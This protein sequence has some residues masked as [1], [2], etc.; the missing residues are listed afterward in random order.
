MRSCL[1]DQILKFIGV[2]LIFKELLVIE[3]DS[4]LHLSFFS[5]FVSPGSSKI[6]ALSEF[7]HPK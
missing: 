5:T 1:C 3:G 4:S 6:A 2:I 7:H